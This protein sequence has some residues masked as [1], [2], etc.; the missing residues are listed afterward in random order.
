MDGLINI[1]WH[2]GAPN[3][4]ILR[5]IEAPNEAP[6]KPF[7]GFINR[8]GPLFLRVYKLNNQIGPFAGLVNI[9]RGSLDVGGSSF[10]KHS[11]G[12]DGGGWSPF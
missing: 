5:H 11:M 2:S 8:A 9:L 4:N 6:N 7:C 1:L 3:V 12:V 10:S